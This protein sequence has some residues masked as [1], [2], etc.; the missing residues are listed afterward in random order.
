[1]CVRSAKSAKSSVSVCSVSHAFYFHSLVVTGSTHM[2]DPWYAHDN[3]SIGMYLGRTSGEVGLG[4]WV[5]DGV[6]VH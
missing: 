5:C 6:D 2:G 1:M 4:G 3:D